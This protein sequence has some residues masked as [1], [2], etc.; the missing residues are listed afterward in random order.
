VTLLFQQS[1]HFFVR[2]LVLNWCSSIVFVGIVSV[3]HLFTTYLSSII[4]AIVLVDGVVGQVSVHVRDVST[5]C[6]NVRVGGEPSQ[7][8]IIKVYAQG[9][10]SSK[11]HVESKVELQV[12]DQ[13]RVVDVGLSNQTLF[14]AS[15]I[16]KFVNEIYTSALTIVTW[17]KD[18]CL[19]NLL[20]LRVELFSSEQ[21]F[22]L[23]NI[24]WQQVGLWKEV[25]L[26]WKVLLH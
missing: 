18:K 9:I 3:W 25:V 11:H 16:F 12:V 26:Y 4:F 10:H 13:E 5:L 6:T 21:C 19:I 8:I 17:L 2:P 7:P 14:E 20:T 23:V 15:Y 24:I 22:K 1:Q